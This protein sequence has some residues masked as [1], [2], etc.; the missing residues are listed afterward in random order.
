MNSQHGR[1]TSIRALMLD[2]ASVRDTASR[3]HTSEG[4]VRVA[5]HRGLAALAA[6]MRRFET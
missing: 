6:R 3:L 5:L 2:G 1:R 4:N